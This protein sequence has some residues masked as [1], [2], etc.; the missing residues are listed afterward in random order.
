MSKPLV[1]I[2]IPTYNRGHFLGETLDSVID[3]TYIN[4]ECILVDDGSSDYTEELMEFYCKVDKRISFSKRPEEKPKGA[5]S[6]RNIGINLSKGDFIQFLDS[7][8]LL[9]EGKLEKQVELSAG[10]SVLMTCKWGGFKKKTDFTS[11]FKYEYHSYRD[12]RKGINLLKTFGKRNEFFPL[13]VYLTPRKLIE[14]A[15]LWNEE[16]TNND[17]AEFF[18]RIILAAKR[19]K[20]TTETAVYYRYSGSDK[21]SSFTN[22][23]RVGSAVKSWELIEEHL[24]KFGME[25]HVYVR[26][27]KKIILNLLLDKYPHL[28]NRYASFLK[29]RKS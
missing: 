7:D 12:F 20:F 21:L 1:S 16:L 4:W 6:C 18:T 10:D 8:D 3:Q 25:T 2:I 29:P 11:R 14:Q 15:G 23:E 27:G 9:R 17:D 13:H 5:S 28:I 26:N 19:I 24:M 22:E